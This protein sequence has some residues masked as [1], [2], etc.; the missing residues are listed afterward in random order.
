[1]TVKTKLRRDRE[2]GS[3]YVMP[4]NSVVTNVT[5]KLDLLKVRSCQASYNSQDRLL[6]HLTYLIRKKLISENRKSL[7]LST[8]KSFFRTH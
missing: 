5:A 3:H 6:I 7:E 2:R 4:R 8:T 1:L